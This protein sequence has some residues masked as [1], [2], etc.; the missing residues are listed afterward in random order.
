MTQ[1]SPTRRFVT[2]KQFADARNVSIDTV[3]R[4]I[5]R[6]EVVAIKLSPRRIGIPIEEIDKPAA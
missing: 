2:K 1:D 3:N 5:A 6:G 4:Q